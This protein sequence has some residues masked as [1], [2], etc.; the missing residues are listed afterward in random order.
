MT[1]H[2]ELVEGESYIDG[3]GK[4]VGG[5]TVDVVDVGVEY[6]TVETN[7]FSG[8]TSEVVDKGIAQKTFELA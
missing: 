2:T 4:G 8:D 7:R 3:R 6:I 1:E 5:H